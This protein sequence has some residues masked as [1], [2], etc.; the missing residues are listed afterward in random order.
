AREKF[1]G[2]I[3]HEFRTPLSLIMLAAADVERR[4]GTQIDARSHASLG[5]ISD[6]SRKLLRLVDELL[7]LAAG[8]ADK[9]VLAPE[10]TNISTLLEQLA[11]SWGLAAEAAGH[12]LEASIAPGVFANVDPVAFERVASNL[13]S[14]A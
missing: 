6:A 5:S 14:N 13:V 3:S 11:A 10:P 7:L 9:L 4:A 2:N 1:F 8:Q 12:S